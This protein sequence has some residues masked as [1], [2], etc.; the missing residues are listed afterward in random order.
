M[1]S[2]REGFD[3]DQYTSIV[4]V[5]GSLL[6]GMYNNILL[7]DARP[8]GEALMRYPG[9]MISMSSFPAIVKTNDSINVMRGECYVVTPRIMLSLD[10]LEGYPN[11]YDREVRPTKA[12]V[13]AWVYYLR[14][15]QRDRR[16]SWV[17]VPDGDWRKFYESEVR[18]HPARPS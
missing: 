4:F 2:D 15:S 6:S 3:D 16:D 11:F 7:R 13:D 10:H 12:G 17:V 18:R 14:Q 8:L 9:I 5:Y 1:Q